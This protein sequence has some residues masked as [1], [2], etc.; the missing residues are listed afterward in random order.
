MICSHGECTKVIDNNISLT[1]FGKD[2]EI[3]NGPILIAIL[4]F[5]ILCF[6]LWYF[7]RKPIGQ[8]L[9]TRHATVKNDLAEAAVLR[10]KAREKLA[11]IEGK[12]KLISDEVDEIKE[13]VAKDAEFEKQRIVKA[14]NEEADRIIERAEATLEREI[15]RAKIK[16]EAEA[17]EAALK[18]AEE[19]VRKQLGEADR[20]RI[21]EDFISQIAS[22]GGS[23]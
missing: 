10:E 21:N 23:N 2:K 9:E 13:G 4:N 19:I 7:A 6:L 22:S 8:F 16:L 1:G 12:L 18:V 11:E 5:A 20:K 3:K 17:I 14:A 15:R